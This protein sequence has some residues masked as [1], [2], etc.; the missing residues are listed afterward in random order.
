MFR[1]L[2]IYRRWLWP[3]QSSLAVVVRCFITGLVTFIIVHHPCKFSV[4]DLGVYFAIFDPSLVSRLRTV[5]SLSNLPERFYVS[6]FLSVVFNRS[7]LITGIR[8]RERERSGVIQSPVSCLSVKICLYTVK[9][10]KLANVWHGSKSF[11]LP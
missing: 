9:C 8:E 6:R 10:L 2:Q 11:S 4:V 5:S 3:Q 1:W 7:L